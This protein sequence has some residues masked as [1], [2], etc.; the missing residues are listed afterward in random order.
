MTTEPI[1][2]PGEATDRAGEVAIRVDIQYTRV[3]H[4]ALVRLT[5]W[6]VRLW[7][8]SWPLVVIALCLAPAI[9]ILLAT[10]H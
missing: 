7:W 10:E 6:P 4:E 1:L 3:D 8:R 5:A 9:V 2:P